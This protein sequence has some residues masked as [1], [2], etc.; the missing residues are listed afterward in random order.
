MTRGGGRSA[1]WCPGCIRS[2]T[3]MRKQMRP[4]VCVRTFEPR[5]LDFNQ[6]ARERVPST[7]W[8]ELSQP[9]QVGL[10]RSSLQAEHFL[11]DPHSE[12]VRYWDLI[13]AVALVFT[14]VV[15]PYEVIFMKQTH[16]TDWL[17]VINRAVDLIFIKD[18]AMQFFLK[19]EVQMKGKYGVRMLKSPSVIRRRYLSTWFPI[20]VV[21]VLPFDVFFVLYDDA[22]SLSGIKIL[23]CLRL[24]RLVKLVRILRTSRLILRWQNYF[25]IS[26]S[27]QKLAKFSFILVL[28]SHWLACVWGL[29]G[30]TFGS[31]LC[32]E[33]GERLTLEGDVPLEEVSWVT[34]L[35]LGGKHSPDNPCVPWHVYIASLHWSVMTITSI[36]YGDIVPVRNEEYI[37]CIGCMLLGG[38][39]WA[40]IIGST[41]GIIS[42]ID[43]V[44]GNFEI[45]TDL[46]NVMMREA[47]VD[48]DRRQHYREYLREAKAYDTMG[49]FRD[50]AQKFSPQ[51]KGELLLHVSS[52]WAETVWYLK[53]A[54]DSLV[55]DLCEILEPKFFSKKESLQDLFEYLCVIE[56]GTVVSAGIILTPGSTFNIDFIV[57]NPLL[58]KWERTISLTYALILCLQ[59]EKFFE[60]ALKHPQ[61]ER[62][63]RKSAMKIAF[64]R[65]LLL[66]A[67][68]SRKMGATSSISK[69]QWPSLLDMFQNLEED[70][71]VSKTNTAVENQAPERAALSMM[72]HKT[73]SSSLEAPTP[74]GLT[75]SNTR[76]QLMKRVS[77][78]EEVAV[79]VSRS[80]SSLTCERTATPEERLNALEAALV[81]SA[82]AAQVQLAQVQRYITDLH[83]V[84]LELAGLGV[85]I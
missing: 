68:K 41:C 47:N 35:F 77:L 74:R 72:L 16:P 40:Y 67:G 34:T 33:H 43:P 84:R 24:M 78:V 25:A 46:L 79:A 3:G 66:C 36:G 63:V 48:K 27:S 62:A 26:F 19:V 1:P 51:L 13:I 82:A 30:L 38:V 75:A 61:F 52:N 32:D 18:M 37:V 71:P 8:G 58:R 53:K 7:T 2:A 22:K 73:G 29:V 59:R 54:P 4:F 57:N 70:A 55:M 81:A 39:L 42:N 56:R 45:N 65:C 80:S 60:L 20:D 17:F 49:H 6:L 44:E 31:E 85:S 9:E 10:I 11:I 83:F 76:E 5:H 23:R 50:V 28:T 21:S 14:G 12:Y 15:T 64:S 69:S